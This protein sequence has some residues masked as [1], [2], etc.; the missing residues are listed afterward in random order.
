M[1]GKEGESTV[2]RGTTLVMSGILFSGCAYLED[3]GKDLLDV[4]GVTLY[5]G[6][7]GLINVRATKVA[8]F[9]LGWATGDAYSWNGRRFSIYQESHKEFGVSAMYWS[10]IERK[11]KQGN[12]DYFEYAEYDN[13]E[14]TTWDWEKDLDRGFYEVGTRLPVFGFGGIDAHVDI[15]QIA[16]FVLGIF[17]VDFAR[18]DMKNADEPPVLAPPVSKPTYEL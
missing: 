12:A 13:S 18:D 16:D 4:A 7:Q 11:D 10:E 3:R 2:K 14:Q 8:Q 9:G 15:M 6:P 5:A 1:W 17:T